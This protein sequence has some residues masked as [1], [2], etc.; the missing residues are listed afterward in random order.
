MDGTNRIR[1][2]FKTKPLG[3]LSLHYVSANIEMNTH[4]TVQYLQQ[5]HMHIV[6]RYI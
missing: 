3:L 2:V 4:N 1:N 6:G 5:K